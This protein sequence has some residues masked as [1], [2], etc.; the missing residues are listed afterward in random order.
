[1][2]YNVASNRA[3]A[4]RVYEMDL[5]GGHSFER[6][7]QF[8][9]IKVPGFYLRRPISVCDWGDDWFKIIFCAVGEG[10]DRLS[11]ARP[12]DKLDILTGLGNG[13]S[14]PDDEKRTALLVGGGMGAAPMLGLAKRLNSPDVALGFRTDSVSFMYEIARYARDFIVAT[15]DGSRGRAGLVTEFLGA[16]Y[17][18]VYVC[19]PAPMM[20]AVGCI[21]PDARFS[22]EERMG[23]GFGACMGCAVETRDGVKRVCADGPVFAGG[24]LI[25]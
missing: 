8:A 21:Y 19:G 5:E 6:P 9:Q 2:I 3:I 11:Q 24:D 14:L 20:K 1:M 23:C 4:Y 10:T 22:L 13:F 7:G 16:E 17:D 15:Q 12:G 18:D 25:W